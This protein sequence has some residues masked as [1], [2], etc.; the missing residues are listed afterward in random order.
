M[1]RRD[2]SQPTSPRK[3]FL[4]NSGRNRGG[5]PERAVP[6]TAAVVNGTTTAMTTAAAAVPLRLMPRNPVP[7]TLSFTPH[8]PKPPT[9]EELTQEALRIVHLP[10]PKALQADDVF[11]GR[12]RVERFEISSNNSGEAAP[13]LAEYDRRLKTSTAAS[14][15]TVPNFLLDVLSDVSS[16]CVVTLGADRLE[17][18]EAKKRLQEYQDYE[19]RK[20]LLVKAAKVKKKSRR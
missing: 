18:N 9:E 19:R 6:L 17:E 14:D 4:T 1:T 20:A 5:T 2:G 13:T 10:L 15:V 3:K 8:V 16:N 7:Q 11:L 12:K